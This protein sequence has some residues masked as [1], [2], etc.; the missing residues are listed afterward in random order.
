MPLYPFRKNN[1]IK[2]NKNPQ[3]VFYE[4]SLRL[5]KLLSNHPYF[6]KNIE[7]L[8]KRYKIPAS[9]IPGISELL[10]WKNEH[11]KIVT[12]LYQERRLEVLLNDF[13][14]PSELQKASLSFAH[15][16]LMPTTSSK[17]ANMKAGSML[18]R[19]LKV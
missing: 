11:R 17:Q 4:T 10:I 6:L 2:G 5:F 19:S 3:E 16:F 9:E 7:K 1:N 18:F 15:D 12:E 8:R 14:I 13:T